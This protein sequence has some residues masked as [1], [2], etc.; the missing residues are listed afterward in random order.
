[1]RFY[2]VLLFSCCLISALACAQGA[3]SDLQQ[4]QAKLAAALN[5]KDF[6][7]VTAL[8]H[9]ALVDFD[10]MAEKPTDWSNIDASGRGDTLRKA[11]SVYDSWNISYRD[12][13]FKVT[14]ATG[15]VAGEIRINRN[16]AGRAPEMTRQRFT[17]TWVREDDKWLLLA[18]HRSP[19]PPGGP[20][21]FP[22]A[23]SDAEK[24]II[25]VAEAAPRHANVTLRDGR[26]LRLLI[27]SMNA[28]KVVEFGTSTG[29]SGLWIL[30]GLRKT[31][32]KLYT[33]ELDEERAD[34]AQANFDNAGVADQV[35]LIR[36][37]GHKN[38]EKI[39]GPIDLAFIDAEKPGYRQYLDQVL[40]KM[41]PG[42][43]ILGHN[44]RFPTPSKD[45]T[46][47]ITTD[48]RL[49]TIFQHMEERGMSVS[50]VKR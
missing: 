18:A 9:P 31:G 28:Q 1:M 23:E 32:G 27:E 14:G 43:L 16:L 35:E 24:K 39:E 33:F 11:L 5:D 7:A 17:H 38:F 20:E 26:L 40:P 8:L 34:I 44:M 2:T 3:E 42:G 25:E 22:V 48:P 47:A 41:R 50:L 46:D 13:L 10:Y 19:F 30:N 12:P 4:A 36:G 37:D 49:D 45:F 29:Y 6:D 15:I 21:K